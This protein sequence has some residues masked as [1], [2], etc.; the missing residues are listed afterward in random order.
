[1]STYA[2]TLH[3]FECGMCLVQCLCLCLCLS[4]DPCESVAGGESEPI[5]ENDPDADLKEKVAE[6]FQKG[7]V[8]KMHN[9]LTTW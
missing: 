7:K 6:Q 3:G 5:A 4:E 1:M 2:A 8:L 9:S